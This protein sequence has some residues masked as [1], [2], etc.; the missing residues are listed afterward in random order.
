MFSNL[1]QFGVSNY[2]PH[3]V[4]EIHAYCKS[5]GYV[6]PTRYQGS[7][8]PFAR[9]AEDELL[10]V[11]RK[12]DIGFIAYSPIA[13]GFL[14]RT[15]DSFRSA[16]N[17]KGRWKKGT[18]SASLYNSLYNKPELLDAL[19]KWE[20]IADAEGIAKA[21]LAY[22]WVAQN[23]DGSKGDGLLFG[24]SSVEQLENTLD[25]LEEGPLTSETTARLDALWGSIKHVAPYDNY[26]GVKK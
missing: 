23:L 2:L 18:F 8:N 5:K 21:E 20:Q 10:P 16:N 1:L 4:E 12:L 24:V 15:A 13:G 11:L 17:D 14:A 22:R 26:H 19:E 3:E 9:H 25:T 6:L 7:Y